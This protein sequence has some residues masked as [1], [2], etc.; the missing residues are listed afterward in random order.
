MLGRTPSGDDLSLPPPLHDTAVAR[1]LP[2][3][4]AGLIRRCAAVAIDLPLAVVLILGPLI[5]LDRGLQALA[6][7]GDQAQAVWRSAAVAWSLVCILGYSPVCIARWGCTLG[8]R[9]LGMEVVRVSDGTR[10]GYGRAVLRHVMNLIITAVP[11]LMVGNVSVINLAPTRQGIHDKA[12]S[13][14]VILRRK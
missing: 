3:S 1:A 4:P 13:S 2:G 7:P 8:K 6:V 10:L 5:G 14:C 11:V 12:V 9:L